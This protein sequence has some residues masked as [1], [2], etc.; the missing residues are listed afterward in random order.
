VLHSAEATVK[1]KQAS[2]NN[3]MVNLNYCKILSP[4]D[5]TVI[6]RNVDI[7]QTVAASL[8]SPVLFQIANDLAKMQIDANVSEAD[9]GSIEEG[10]NVSFSVDAFPD[11]KFSGRVKQIRNSPTTVQ[12]VVT[13]DV[14]IE[15]SNPT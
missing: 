1:I 9:I 8:S 15:V 13:Y 10:Q 12:N 11:R 6:S 14:V 2:L 3:A 7:G 5:G 4:V